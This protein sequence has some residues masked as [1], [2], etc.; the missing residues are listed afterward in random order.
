MDLLQEVFIKIYKSIEGFKEGNPILPWIKRITVNT[1]LN[2]VRGRPDTISL[3]EEIDEENNTLESL[4]PSGENVE[5]EVIYS[6][7]K[8]L[9]EKSI[10]KLP[11]EVRMAVI[12]RH[13]KGMSYEEISKL[14]KCPLGTVKTYIYRGRETLRR[15]LVKK[16]ILEV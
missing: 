9:I 16:G 12:L 4:V 10:R 6:D 7:T 1:C 3:N 13:V 5:N 8:R 11:A 14:M 15:E 2:Y